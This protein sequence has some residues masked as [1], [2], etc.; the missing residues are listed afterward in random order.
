M[1]TVLR[2]HAGPI[3]R[4]QADGLV[5]TVPAKV[6][7]ALLV[8][9]RRGDGYHEIES[10]VVAVTLFDEL[11]IR[12][13]SDSVL[14]MRT[15]GEASPGDVTNLVWRSAACLGRLAGKVPGGLLEIRKSIPAGT[16]LG[17]GSADAAAA[18]AG[19]NVHWQAGL[20]DGELATLA[21]NVGADVPLFFH[22][23]AAVIRGVGE[24][25]EAVA[26]D[27]PGWLVLAVPPF[28]V[29]TAAVYKRWTPEPPPLG[30]PI[31]AVLEAHAAKAAELSEKLV[32]ML[33]KPA[34][35]LYPELARLHGAM[36]KIANR[37]VRLTGSG[38][39]L[40][41]LFDGQAEASRVADRLRR[42]LGVRTW[43]LKLLTPTRR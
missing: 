5:V 19:L 10:L 26:F 14:E 11:A 20:S 34:F 18:L 38:A 36:T 42:E 6:N 23:P 24:I 21:A 25:A 4:H 37:P 35:R 30:R 40:F 12:G 28:G 43:L 2:G 13:P 41:A 9:G 1:T 39:G 8:H 29:S 33:E 15:E 31:E 22:L 27:W 32:N 7:L 3:V 17:G 16:G